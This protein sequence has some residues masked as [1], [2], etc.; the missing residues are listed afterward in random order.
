MRVPDSVRIARLEHDNEKLR[1]SLAERPNN[2][3]MR[4]L[5]SEIMDLKTRLNTAILVRENKI[6]MLKAE[7]AA[8]RAELEEM[9]VGAP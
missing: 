8:L 6:A 5:I 1:K 3:E 2:V 9:K 4:R 7:I